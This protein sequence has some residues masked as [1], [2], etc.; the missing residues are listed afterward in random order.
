MRCVHRLAGDLGRADR[1]A[2]IQAE[3]QTR[4]RCV[5]R[6]HEAQLKVDGKVLTRFDAHL[7]ADVAQIREREVARRLL[8]R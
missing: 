8:R 7:A 6:C 1:Q 5:G 2:R 4:E 3:V